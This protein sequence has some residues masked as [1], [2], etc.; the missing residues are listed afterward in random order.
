MLIK[1]KKQ[2]SMIV[3]LKP[4]KIK[5]PRESQNHAFKNDFIGAKLLKKKPS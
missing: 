1:K 3:K 2:W 4:T 5:P